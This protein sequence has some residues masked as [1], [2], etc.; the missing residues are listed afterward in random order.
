MRLL[1]PLLTLLPSAPPSIS[2]LVGWC[3]V[4]QY[5]DPYLYVVAATYPQ[6]PYLPTYLLYSPT[7]SPP[8]SLSLSLPDLT[9]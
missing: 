7:P 8:F 2:S 1:P 4:P 6:V 3:Y 5:L 9:S